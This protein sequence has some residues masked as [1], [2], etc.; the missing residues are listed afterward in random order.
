MELNL[1]DSLEEAKGLAKKIK[2]KN[3]EIYE[4]KI[5]A[6]NPKSQVL[7]D[8][9]RGGGVKSNPIENFLI[10]LEKKE[11]E[12]DRLCL[13][14]CSLWNGVTQRLKKAGADQAAIDMLAYRFRENYL[15][16]KCSAICWQELPLLSVC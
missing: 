3:T 14:L 7:S 1:L 4:L 9:P 15:W 16:K 12:R 8:M 2:D 5:V 11:A 6:M 10:R 13:Q